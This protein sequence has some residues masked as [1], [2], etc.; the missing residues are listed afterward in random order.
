MAINPVIWNGI[1]SIYIIIY[2]ISNFKLMQEV[3]VYI[4]VAAAIVFLIRKFFFSSKK[5]SGCNPDC[6]C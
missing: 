1:I 2:C 3:F 6:N 4:I 5:S